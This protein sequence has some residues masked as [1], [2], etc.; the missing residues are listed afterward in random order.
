MSQQLTINIQD[1]EKEIKESVAGHYTPPPLIIP[2]NNQKEKKHNTANPKK[3]QS[4]SQESY[5]DPKI[6]INQGQTHRPTHQ[7]THQRLKI[8][9]RK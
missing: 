6:Q 3:S 5:Q 4:N 1:L 7:K 9:L 8:Y 2:G